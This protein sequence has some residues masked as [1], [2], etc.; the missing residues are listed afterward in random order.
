MQ[1]LWLILGLCILF[2]VACGGQS[3]GEGT[4]GGAADG[5][6]TVE[7]IHLSHPPILPTV[8]DVEA[9]LAEYGDSVAWRT[10]DFD[11]DEGQ[12]FAEE[13]GL[14][15]HT[16]I[17]IFINGEMEMDLNGR[18]VKFYSFPQGAGVGDIV[19]EGVWTL[20]DFRAALDQATNQ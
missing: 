9:I 5:A 8:K 11:T 2:L 3:D 12:A 15:D 18:L 13:H 14:V 7:V 6:V 4:T 1:K 20:D 17:A 16:P 19:A 10:F